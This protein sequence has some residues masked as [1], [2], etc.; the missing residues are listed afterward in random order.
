MDEKTALQAAH[1]TVSNLKLQHAQRPVSPV[2]MV[3]TLSSSLSA[4]R[5][6]VPRNQPTA[7]ADT[8][9][10]WPATIDPQAWVK[11]QKDAAD[12]EIAALLLSLVFQYTPHQIAE[13]VGVSL[14]TARYRTG[15]AARQLGVHVERLQANA[16]RA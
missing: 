11:F 7:V 12:V 4:Y 2:D 5:K 3:R 14:G 16:V 1:K 6:L 15:K 13:G 9:W 8:V 10:H